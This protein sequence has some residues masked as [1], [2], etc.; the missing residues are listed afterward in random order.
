MRTKRTTVI[1]DFTEVSMVYS[2]NF[3][4]YINNMFSISRICNEEPVILRKLLNLA[5]TKFDVSFVDI[6]TKED[7]ISVIPASKVYKL[8]KTDYTEIIRS[9]F[10][11]YMLAEQDMYDIYDYVN[12][13]N[14]VWNSKSRVEI[15][16]GKFIKKVNPEFTDKEI[17]DFVNKFKALHKTRKKPKMKLISGD[18][19]KYWYDQDNYTHTPENRKENGLG[20]LG[21]SCMRYGYQF[22]DLYAKNPQVCKLL[23]LHPYD[24][25]DTILGRALIWKL[26]DGRFY[27]DRIYTHFDSD[28]HIFRT[29]A[30]KK[31]WLMHYDYL[32]RYKKEERLEIELKESKF[33]SY[34][35]MDSFS[36]LYLERNILCNEERNIRRKDGELIYHLKTANGKPTKI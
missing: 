23:I 14:G 13:Y 30:Q 21:K 6:T 19:I 26:T 8:Y 12:G 36:I 1:T 3:S 2:T 4:S 7:T 5:G 34:P 11:N 28:V 10:N 24:S 25:E 18:D 32:N 22:F 31:G 16:I 35:Y 17:E 20:S 29:Y 33:K 9:E 27:M 15:K